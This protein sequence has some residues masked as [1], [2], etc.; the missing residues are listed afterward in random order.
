MTLLRL[1]S[2]SSGAKLACRLYIELKAQSLP[3]K[4]FSS[5]HRFIYETEHFN[6]VAELLE[7]LGR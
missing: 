4:R 3:F 6:G 1:D 5:R 2:Q 7:I